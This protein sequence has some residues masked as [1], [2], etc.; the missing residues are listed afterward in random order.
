MPPSA[1]L[2]GV[3]MLAVFVGI[4]QLA[5]RYILSYRLTERSIKVEFIKYKIIYIKYSD[6][7]EIRLLTFIESF[8]PWA[9]WHFFNRVFYDNAIFI[10]RRKFGPF[11]RIV[12]TPDNPDLVFYEIYK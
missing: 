4:I 1:L 10:K 6:I 2:A 11:R 5:G 12:I 3:I 8:S 9:G 7:S